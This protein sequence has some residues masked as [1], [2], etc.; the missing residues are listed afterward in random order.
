MVPYF[1]GISKQPM[2]VGDAWAVPA[3]SG[4][5]DQDLNMTLTSF[6]TFLGRRV[7]RFDVMAI[8]PRAGAT[9]RNS[10]ILVDPSSGD[11]MAAFMDVSVSLDPDSPDV[12]MHMVV[13]MRRIAR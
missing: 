2:T 5:L 12:M 10:Y 4:V 6:P 1:D 3:K 8:D 11:T 13:D 7:G 9:L